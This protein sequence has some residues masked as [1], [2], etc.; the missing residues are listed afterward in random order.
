L[1]RTVFLEYDGSGRRTDFSV[2][3]SVIRSRRRLT[4]EQALDLMKGDYTGD[5]E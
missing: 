2:A 5:P 4:Y 3:P 1:T